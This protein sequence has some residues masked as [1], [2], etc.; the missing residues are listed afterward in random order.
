VTAD[1][2][3]RSAL[4][5]VKLAA[6]VREHVG[7]GDDAVGALEGA[8]ALR[9]GDD[10]W[11]LADER[12]A[13]VLGPAL[14]W[15]LRHGARGTVNVLVEGDSAGL[16]AR[17]ARFF[18]PP[19]VVWQVQGRELALAPPAE[20]PARPE[21]SPAA[22]VF[23]DTIVAAGVE[24]TVEHGVLVGEVAGLEVCRVV[25]DP[26]TGAAR[27]EV[28]VGVHDREAFRLLHG[29]VA[30]ADALRAVADTVRAHRRWDA[31]PHPLNRLGRERLLRSLLV[32]RP[33]LVG[34]VALRPA[35]PPVPRT[36]L[37]DP[38]PCA[39]LGHDDDGRSV[40]VVC[41]TGGDLDAVPFAADARAAIDP[42]AD[43]VLAVPPADRHAVT[44]ELAELLVAPARVIAV[45]IA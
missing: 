24:P 9:R 12:P 43:L 37:K 21:A 6:L 44:V 30:T 32:A 39:A 19:V 8:A 11:V 7:E 23:A 40:V 42:G 2:Q 3:R 33:E 4:L 27:L 34:L 16:S 20:R 31:P 18:A 1:P 45:S 5:A 41:S 25:V 22:L 15:A 14:A 26:D 17:R 29:D 13:R 36:S 28:G 10:A 38:V 35:P